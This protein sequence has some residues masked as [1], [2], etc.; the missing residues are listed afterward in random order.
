MLLCA[1]SMDA[2]LIFFTFSRWFVRWQNAP[3]FL[4]W[5]GDLFS[6][7]YLDIVGGLVDFVTP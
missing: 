3:I 5:E 2:T 1:V 4:C 6:G 7:K